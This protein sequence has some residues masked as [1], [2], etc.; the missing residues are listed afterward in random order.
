MNYYIHVP[1]C[2]SKCNYCELYSEVGVSNAIINKFLISLENEICIKMEKLKLDGNLINPTNSITIGGG[3]P[4]Y[5]SYTQL[6]R[7]LRFVLTT[8]KKPIKDLSCEMNPFKCDV[9]K[10]TILKKYMVNRISFGIQTN[11]N[12]I[13]KQMNRS[14]SHRPEIIINKAKELKFKTNLDYII[15]LP[16]QKIEDV[17]K[18]ICFIKKNLPNSITVSQLRIGREEMA[19]YRTDKSLPSPESTKA[20]YNLFKKRLLKLGYFRLLNEYFSLSRDIPFS[21]PLSNIFSENLIGFGPFAVSYFK[22]KINKNGNNLYIYNNYL[23]N[24]KL[25]CF[26]KTLG[27]ELKSVLFLMRIEYEIIDLLKIHN[28]FGFDIEKRL[29]KE[30]V[31]CTNNGLITIKNKK[32]SL[33]D[34]GMD[35]IQDVNKILFKKYDRLLKIMDGLFRQKFFKK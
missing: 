13:L 21:V 19:I 17:E 20:M 23:A 31:E 14:Y 10:L 26:S 9:K 18:S 4:N 32:L 35:N 29:K 1:F 34:Y 12:F 3:T 33:T 22:N 5:L 30:I 25:L 6:D 24:N 28:E 7:F 11:N 2:Y 16:H 27:N 15:G 8:F